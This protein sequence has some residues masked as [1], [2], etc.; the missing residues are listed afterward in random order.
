LVD[1]YWWNIKQI[2]VSISTLRKLTIDIYPSFQDHN[3]HFTVTIDVGNSLSLRCTSN[4]KVKFIIVNPTFVVD[5]HVDDYLYDD[6]KDTID[7]TINELCNMN[8]LQ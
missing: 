1:C 5:A 3:D 7:F 4:P 8:A 2:N 6:V